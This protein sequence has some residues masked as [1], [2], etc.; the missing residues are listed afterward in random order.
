MKKT[1]L[2]LLLAFFT[3]FTSTA[4]QVPLTSLKKGFNLNG[5][6]SGASF[7]TIKTTSAV[8]LYTIPVAST[9]GIF[10]VTA[11]ATELSGTTSGT[12]NLEVSQDG[13]NW[14]SYYDSKGT[15]S[16]LTLSDVTTPQ[17]FRWQILGT[18]DKYYRI[19]AVGGG[20]VSVRI[21]GTYNG[22]IK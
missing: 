12:V 14:S 7:D 11:V 5:S 1:T 18:A 6:P 13:T 8:Y 22:R 4:Q 3:F 20:T 16:V 2:V 17:I 9:M 19:K 15:A 10:N 21:E